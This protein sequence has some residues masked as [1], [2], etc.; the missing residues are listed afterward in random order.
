MVVE[1]ALEVISVIDDT[2]RF[3]LM[4]KSAAAYLEGEASDFIGKSIKVV[5]PKKDADARMEK[6]KRIIETGIGESEEVEVPLKM[7]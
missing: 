1:N 4:N 7:E 3:L 6:F 5:L 2:G